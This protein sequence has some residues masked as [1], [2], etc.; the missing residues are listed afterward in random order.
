MT[1]LRK[2]K[3]SIAPIFILIKETTAH[4]VDDHKDDRGRED[5]PYDDEQQFHASK[6]ALPCLF[7]TPATVSRLTS[8]EMATDRLK[9]RGIS[10]Y[11]PFLMG[12]AM[13]ALSQKE[14][15]S[16]MNS[17]KPSLPRQAEAASGSLS[18]RS[19]SFW[20]CFTR[21]LRAAASVRKLIRQ[22]LAQPKRLH[23][24]WK[25]QHRSN[26]SHQ[27][28]ANK[29]TTTHTRPP[30]GARSNAC[31]FCAW[32]ITAFNNPEFCPC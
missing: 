14:D 21:S 3:R 11:V 23:P 26:L 9:S 29:P 16:W 27:P 17:A 12:S 1:V 25:K 8:A 13:L 7:A 28:Q 2:A 15:A 30:Q 20:F 19:L 22:Q 4:A 31:A 6:L 18:L 5:T 10:A 24:L 32:D